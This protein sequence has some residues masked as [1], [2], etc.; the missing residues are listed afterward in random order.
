MPGA[1]GRELTASVRWVSER[2]M[3]RVIPRITGW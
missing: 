2:G 3:W 1:A